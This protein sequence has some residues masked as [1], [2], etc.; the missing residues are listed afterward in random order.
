MNA[1]VEG[2]NY[3]FDE[4]REFADMMEADKEVL[5]GFQVLRMRVVMALSI[6]AI[7]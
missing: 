4:S 6:L 5:K 1:K 2:L 3:E 7:F